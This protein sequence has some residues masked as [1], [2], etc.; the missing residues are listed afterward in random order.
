MLLYRE[1]DGLTSEEQLKEFRT[2]ME[3]RFGPMPPE[4]EELLRI[5]PLR[6]LGRKAGAERLQLKNGRM[7]LYFVGNTD[8]PFYKS[9]TFDNIIKYAMTNFR[10]C[11]IK[12]DKGR[13]RIHINQVN[14]VETA[15][16]TLRDML[17]L[18]E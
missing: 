5:A 1:L 4:G 14:S 11:V 13:R 12:E 3:D 17:K 8:S 7:T 2:R 15:L 16:N 9:A 18:K 10:N 6:Q